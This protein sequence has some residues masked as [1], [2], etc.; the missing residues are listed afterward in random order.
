M[1]SV[2]AA[3]VVYATTQVT[4]AGTWA[5]HITA[6]PNNIPGL[7]IKQTLVSLLGIDLVTTPLSVLSNSLGITIDGLLN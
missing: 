7:Q 4:T 1:V 3:G 2:Q 6:L 5:V